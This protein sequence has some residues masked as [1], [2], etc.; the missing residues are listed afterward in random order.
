MQPHL[1]LYHAFISYYFLY[2]RLLACAI[3]RRRQS[4]ILHIIESKILILQCQ[5]CESFSNFISHPFFSLCIRCAA[6]LMFAAMY[7]LLFVCAV[8]FPLVYLSINATPA[9]LVTVMCSG[10]TISV[11][12]A[13]G[14]IFGPRTVLIF[15]YASRDDTQLAVADSTASFH[16]HKAV[17]SKLRSDSSPSMGLH[18]AYT[19]VKTRITSGKLISFSSGERSSE[20]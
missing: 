4:C 1:P 9:N 18:Q 5:R 15:H 13:L 11:A 20:A 12:C 8:T 6:Y 3:H 17:G 19:L 14:L 10:F 16:P 2:C 7:L